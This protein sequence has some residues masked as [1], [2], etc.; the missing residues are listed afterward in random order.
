[1]V[2]GRTEQRVGD[3]SVEKES[4]ERVMKENERKT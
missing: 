3:E 4:K 1:M 2:G